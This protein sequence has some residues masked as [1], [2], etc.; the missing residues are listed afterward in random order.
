MRFILFCF[1]LICF[2]EVGAQQVSII[3]QPTSITFPKTAGSFTIKNRITLIA[4]GSGQE[5]AVFYLNEYLK[6]T[7]NI[8][9]LIW[10]DTV[11]DNAIH[12]NYERMDH[13]VPGAYSIDVQKDNIYLNGDNEAGLFNA[14]QSLIQLLPTEK[15]KPLTI[16]FLS[17]TDGP[18]FG[19][20]GMHLDVGRHFMPVPFVKK[21]IDM[22]ARHK[23][24][25]FHW[26][27]TEDQGWRI[28]ITKYPELT[29]VGAWR[30]GTIKGRYPGE[31]SNNTFHGGF[32]TQKQVREIVEYASKRYITI[33][34][35]I[36][37]PGHASAAI[38]S[39]P[40][41][42]C[43]PAEPT[44]IPANMI[45]DAAKT[46]GGK[47]V[48]ETW[49]V[50]PDVFCAGNDSTFLFLQN[51][52]DEVAGLFP[53]QYI[54]IGGDECPKSNWKRCPRCQQRMKDLKLKNEFELQNYFI[55]RMEEYIQKKGK[56]I[57]G[58]DEI[59]E[60]GLAPNATVMSWRGEQG[61]IAA[62]KMKHDVIMTPG[63][64][65]YFDHSPAKVEDSLTQGSYTPLREVYDYEPLPKGLNA[66][67]QKFVL[68]SQGNVWTEYM[69]NPAKVEY[70]VFPRAA[71]LSEILWVPKTAKNYSQFE[72]KI[73]SLFKRY[74]LW[75]L[76]Y[77][78]AYY[79]LQDSVFALNGKLTWLLRSTS[80]A[81]IM[82]TVGN[83]GDAI[84]DV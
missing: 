80:D 9:C 45:S 65:V 42:S 1:T 23:L 3:P 28:E 67:Q 79:D 81:T 63:N 27:L 43:F 50:F 29:S 36:E 46:A 44:I 66:G 10:M 58:W 14:V 13:P 4:H 19:Y 47:L 21:F 11:I 78:N 6:Q 74:Q 69:S 52:I 5:N 77:S 37:M 25:Y 38:A 39:Y 60:G 34:P 55:T 41:L 40:W 30:K 64:F 24:N 82:A 70:M 16:P 17:I 76:N 26:H 20:R 35:E 73:P 61:G 15:N 72:K 84:A 8:T 54:H 68:G 12:F 51:V 75:N 2:I 56:S 31:G 53:G 83:A 59:L 22:M 57:I 18:R 71:A 48:Q 7:Y 49:G 33:I 32:Y 62:A